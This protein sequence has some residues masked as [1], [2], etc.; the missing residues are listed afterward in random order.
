MKKETKAATGIVALELSKIVPSGFN[1]RKIIYDSDLQELEQSIKQSGVLQ[2]IIV[3]PRGRKFE[4]V[5]GERRYSASVLAKTKTIPA[6]VRKLSDDEALELAITENLQRKDISPIE[7]AEA[8]RRLSDTGRYDVSSL[9]LRF[10]KSEAYIRNRMKLND[11]TED[12]L[13]LVNR[14]IINIS[15]ALELCKYSKETQ[16]D[17][18]KKHLQD[19]DEGYYNNWRGLT[20]KEFAHRLERDYSGELSRYHFDKTECEKCPFNTACYSLFPVP[21]SEGKCTDLSCLRKKNEQHLTD[22]LKAVLR[23][24]PDTEICKPSYNGGHEEIYACLSEQGYQVET[25]RI[26]IFPDE[27]EKPDRN[28]FENEED[29]QKAEDEYYGEMAD[30]K[31]ETDELDDLFANGKAKQ[32]VTLDS[33]QIKFGYI[34]VRDNDSDTATANGTKPLTTANLLLKQDRRN[35]EIAVENIVEDT[36]RF[37][38][39]NDAPESDFS[40]FEDKLLY[41]TMMDDLK[42]EHIALFTDD[43]EKKWHLTDEDKIAVINSLT[44]E[45]KTVIRRDFLVSHLSDACGVSK[46]SYLML[47]FARQHFPETLAETETKYND[48]YQKRHE[49]ITEK[50]Q[51]LQT[52]AETEVEEALEEVA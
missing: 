43:T 45:Q 48:I 31:E 7:E 15:I 47:E 19:D 4:I 41:F 22:A 20:A 8:Y 25:E 34:L 39:E 5:C 35:K 49:R 36:R 6:I 14:D 2:P 32:A 44:E 33:N 12:I 11:L 10:G 46:K 3:R 27:P 9:A 38:R 42:R 16:A 26:N 17:I 28:T 1:P 13:D 50:L 18:F 52:Q 23:E 29:F 40:E 30:Y 37:I 24:N 21:N 51:A